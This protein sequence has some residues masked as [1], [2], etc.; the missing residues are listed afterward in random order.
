MYRLVERL[1]SVLDLADL[2]S[3]LVLLLGFDR[4]DDAD[5]QD[6]LVEESVGL[7]SVTWIVSELRR[8]CRRSNNAIEINSSIAETIRNVL[9]VGLERG[10]ERVITRAR[11]TEIVGRRNAVLDSDLNGLLED[12]TA[13][14]Y[15]DG[16]SVFGIVIVLRGFSLVILSLRIM[17]SSNEA[18]EAGRRRVVRERVSL[19]G[20]A[21]R[22]LSC[23]TAYAGGYCFRGQVFWFVGLLWIGLVRGGKYSFPTQ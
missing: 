14:E 9:D 6:A 5:A 1:V 19:D 7:L 11:Y 18:L 4:N 15:R 23:D 12:T 2:S 22:F 10:R 21:R 8:C 16:V 17:F 20:S 13:D 3:V